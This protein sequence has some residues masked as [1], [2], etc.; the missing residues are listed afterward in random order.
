M[1]ADLLRERYGR[2]MPSW[3][4]NKIIDS[5]LSHRTW[6][7]FKDDPLPDGMLET[8]IAAGQSA[9][10][11]SNLQSWS[12]IAVTDKDRRRSL[13]KLGGGQSQI[14]EAPL[15]L[16]FIADLSRL[17][18]IADSIGHPRDGLEYFE[19]FLVGAI[20]AA[21]A[22]QNVTIAA[23]SFGLGTCYLGVLRNRPEEMAEF[24]QLP[25]MAAV[26]FGLAVGYPNDARPFHIKPRLAQSS[27]LHHETYS[28][29]EALGPV[30]QYEAA[31][32]AFN[33]REQRDQARWGLHSSH[34]VAN[35]EILAGRD[36]LAGALKRMG[37][38][39]K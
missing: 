15:T 33:A 23:E 36:Q 28:I 31:L 13:M 17:A 37:F 32:A 11:S 8:L 25:P 7:T 9:A 10:S 29:M 19:M 24:L 18:A 12:V 35:A 6:R 26:V 1:Q 21:L 3:P 38:P 16:C 27:V 34:R 5:I 4:S 30:P 14:G 22:A 2:E 39:L 20:D